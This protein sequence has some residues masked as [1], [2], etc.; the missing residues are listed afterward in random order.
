MEAKWGVSRWK[1][2]EPSL[3]VLGI[4]GPNPSSFPCSFPEAQPLTFYQILIIIVPK[5]FIGWHTWYAIHDIT[6]AGISSCTRPSLPDSSHRGAS[7]SLLFAS[8][9]NAWG[10]VEQTYTPDDSLANCYRSYEGQPQS[11]ER[12]P[13]LQIILSL[14]WVG[15]LISG[16]APPC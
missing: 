9:I 16:N 11:E 7:Y 5:Y 3:A 13:P 8:S 1:D 2:S 10:S 12:S 14:E 4:F 15:H 6:E